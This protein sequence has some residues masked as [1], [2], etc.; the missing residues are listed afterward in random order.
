MKYLFSLKSKKSK[1]VLKLYIIVL[2]LILFLYDI[3]LIATSDCPIINP[4]KI[5]GGECTTGGCSQ[6]LIDSGECTIENDIIEKQWFTCVSKY[7]DVSIHYSTLGITSNGDIVCIS[8]VYFSTPC[9]SYTYYL[10]G[11]KKNGRPLFLKNNEETYF[12]SYTSNAMRNEGNIFSI[13]LNTTNEDKEY[14]VA[15]ANNNAN[16][17][18]YDSNDINYASRIEAKTFFNT[19][20]NYFQ[21]SSIF[22]LKNKPKTYIIGSVGQD[23]G[24]NNIFLLTKCI[25]YNKDISLYPPDRQYQ[26]DSIGN[27][28]N[29]ACCFE[30]ENSYIFCFYLKDESNLKIN[31]YNYDLSE[32]KSTLIPITCFT[33]DMFYRCVHFIGNSG[34]FAYIDSDNNFAILFKEYKSGEIIDYF[35][36]KNKITIN[37]NGFYNK[38]KLADMIKLKDKKIGLATIKSDKTEFN[39]YIINN[40]VDEKIKIR[41]YNIKVQNL[42][43]FN[44]KDEMRLNLYNDL[45]SMAFCSLASGSSTTFAFIMVFGYPNSSDFTYDISGDLI[46]FQNPIIK[47]YQKCF[48]ENNIFGFFFVGIKIYN[49]TDGLKLI[50]SENQKEIKKGDIISNNTDI[51][52]ILTNEIN[53]QSSGRI[54]YSMTVMEPDYETYNSF[55]IDINNTY[56]GENCDDENTINYF[57]KQ[58]YFGRISYYDITFDLTK[59][60]KD[61]NENCVVCVK[62]SDRSCI[63]CRYLYDEILYSG[64]LCYGE[65]DFATT[66]PII[67]TTIPIITTTLSIEDSEETKI[68][69]SEITTKPNISSTEIDKNPTILPI[70][71]TTPKKEENK[72]NEKVCTN[73]E[74][75]NNRCNNGKITVNQIDD[76]KNNILTTNYTKENTI[77]KTENVIIQLSTFEDQKNSEDPDVSN[78]DLGECENILKDANN[79]SR[80]DSL[81]VFKTDIKT[82]DLSNTYV[83]YEIYN[84]YTLTKLDLNACKDVQISVSA[85]VKLDNSMESLIN[86]LSGSGYNIFNEN[87]S[88]YNDICSTYTSENGTDMLLSDRKNDILTLSQNQTMC[89]TGCELQSYNSTTRKAKCDCT[90]KVETLNNLDINNLFD[91]KEIVQ[92]FYSTLRNSNFKVLKCYKL[93]IDFSKIGKNYGEIFL[94]ILFSIFLILTIIYF[95]KGQKQIHS[96]IDMI[97]KL[98]NINNNKNIKKNKNTKKKETIKEKKKTIN[99]NSNKS[100][101]SLKNNSPKSKSKIKGKNK[102][103]PPKRS[104]SI[105]IV[106]NKSSKFTSLRKSSERI[107]NKRASKRCI[108]NNILLNIQ[109]IKPKKT[110]I[111]NNKNEKHKKTNKILGNKNS[112]YLDSNTKQLMKSHSKDKVPE[113]E[114]KSNKYQE[115]FKN[116][117][118]HEMNNLE[119]EQAI[120]YDKRTYL[121]YYWSLLKKKQLVL[122]TFLPNNDYNLLTIKIALFIISF[123]LFFTINGFFFSDSTMHKVYEDKGS[124]NLINQ[125]PQILYSS[126]I[127]A[128]INTILKQLCLSE[129][130]ILQIK[131]ERAFS[132]IVAKSKKIESCLRIKFIIFFF[133]SFILM[134]FFW[135]FISCFCAVYIN[136]QIILIKDTLISFATSMIYPFGLNLI[137]GMFRIPALRTKKKDKQCIYK[138]SLIIALI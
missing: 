3:D 87:D 67:T 120:K 108:N 77:I 36:T 5:N 99:R 47:L 106:R 42:Y 83:V 8:S 121:Q 7:S 80:D 66:I 25:F 93:L 124:F 89:Q 75:L 16:F 122:F 18:L 84:P 102:K 129:K 119:Y 91:Q 62:N 32:E 116:F 27:E 137:P 39:F 127:S 28:V 118:D 112:I 4:F 33:K 2:D 45:V 44:I 97:I 100:V 109:V 117:N 30:S 23:S 128:I 74:V 22:E 134:L 64:K 35:N 131:E 96:F 12:T 133:I 58:N 61:C 14:I 82:V 65:N 41:H 114:N 48:I 95:I 101:K 94:T 57:S 26:S 13:K 53:I 110:K 85:P 15:Y 11:I 73:D 10:Y 54:E 123:G 86:S 70:S 105:S 78:I 49:F 59:I 88:F 55:T 135:Y 24:W 21:Y 38:T 107:L 103:A 132:N 29:T 115:K 63:V 40:Y 51:E 9:E 60:T 113:K 136:T 43:R 31:I 68:S 72:N 126:V 79:I 130:N 111:I 50:D 90:V 125:I 34:A 92:N 71:T 81:I 138:M 1:K 98:K 6:S 76:I 69:T 52:L 104:K 37:N 19:K 20:R 46:Q 56:C 17:E